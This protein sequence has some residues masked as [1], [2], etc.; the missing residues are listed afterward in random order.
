ARGI[1][2]AYLSHSQVRVKNTQEETFENSIRVFILLQQRQVEPVVL[3]PPSQRIF[4]VLRERFKDLCVKYKSL[5][6][7]QVQGA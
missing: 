5:K 2:A 3:Q 7:T 1:V 4:D 6:E